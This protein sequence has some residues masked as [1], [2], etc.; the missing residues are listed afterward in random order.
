MLIYD[1]GEVYFVDAAEI[2]I[3]PFWREEGTED[4]RARRP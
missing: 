4:E 1:T 2:Y 3:P